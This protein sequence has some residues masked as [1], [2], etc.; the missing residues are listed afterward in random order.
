M[1]STE[2]IKSDYL[3][4]VHFTTSSSEFILFRQKPNISFWILTHYLATCTEE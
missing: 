3:K 2:K 4:P 1:H